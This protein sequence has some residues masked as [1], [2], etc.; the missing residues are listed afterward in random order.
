[1]MTVQIYAPPDRSPEE[2]TRSVVD[3]MLD[4]MHA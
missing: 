1:M 2:A 3:I 4:G